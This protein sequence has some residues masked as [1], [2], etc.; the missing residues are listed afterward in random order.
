MSQLSLNFAPLNITGN[1]SILVGR[2]PFDSERLAD[3]RAEFVD[4]HVFHRSGLD[5]TIIDIP[6]VKDI[7]PL[8]NVS[9]T[10]DLLRERRL[11]PTLLSASLLRTFGGVRDIMSDRPVSVVGPINRGYLLHP[12]LPDWIQ[13]RTLL[14]FDTRTIHIDGKSTFGIVCETRLKS[15]TQLPVRYSKNSEFRFRAVTSPFGSPQQTNGSWTVLS[16]SEGSL[17]WKVTF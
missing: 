8:G 11:W 13:R 9:E 3:L 5:D 10:I 14:R 4:T 1:T 17:R 6:I 7:A 16:S 12:D 15:F 2:Q